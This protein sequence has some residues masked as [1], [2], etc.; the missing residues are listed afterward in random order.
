M[1]VDDDTVSGPGID[2]GACISDRVR[3]QPVLGPLLGNVLSEDVTTGQ[4]SV[5]LALRTQCQCAL[6]ECTEPARRWPILA[7]FAYH[8]RVVNHT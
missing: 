5:L 8:S 1:I 7:R 6:I 3:S 2:A 4:T